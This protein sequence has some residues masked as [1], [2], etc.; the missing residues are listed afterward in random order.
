MQFLHPRQ[1]GAHGKYHV[2]HT[3]DTPLSNLSLSYSSRAGSATRI[4][5]NTI[6]NTLPHFSIIFSIALCWKSRITITFQPAENENRNY[7]QQNYVVTH[8]KISFQFDYTGAL[9][10]GLPQVV[11][12]A[13]G[14][15]RNISRGL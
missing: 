2:C 14:V 5:L 1:S 6:V 10:S 8:S 15:R 4:H 9:N 11:N 12:G 13:M 3:L 7:K